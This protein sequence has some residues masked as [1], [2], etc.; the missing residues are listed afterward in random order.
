MKKNDIAAIILAAGKGTRMKSEVPK[1][2]HQVCGRPMLG[3]VLDLLKGLRIQRSAVVLGHKADQVRR[4]LPAGTRSVLQKKLIGTADAVKEAVPALGG[5]SG[6]TVILYGD[7][8]L[9]KKETIARLIHRHRQT[10]AAATILTAKLESPA[11]YG[12][13]LRDHLGAIYG[14][15]EEKDAD[16]FQKDIKEINTG[17]ICFDTRLLKTMLRRVRPNNRKKEYYLTDVIGLLYRGGY[18]VENVLLADFNEALGV[19]SRVDLA[20]AQE[21]MQK[22]ILQRYMQDG[23]TIIDPASTCIDYGVKIGRD[24]T[25]YPFTVIEN[26]VTIGKQ[27]CVG[28][29]AHIK[30][31]ARIKDRMSVGLD[32]V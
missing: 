24:S 21:V 1:V 2:L 28:P 22:R 31:G 11:G 17:F 29:F 9:L 26:D 4:F 27:C 30:R 14:I 13:I 18:S 19:N 8:P 3:Y 32:T 5:F 23:I 20:Q 7:T 15:Q 10:R 6:I 16:D 12:R 25:I